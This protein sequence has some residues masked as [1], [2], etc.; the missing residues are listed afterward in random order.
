MDEES[1]NDSYSVDPTPRRSVEPV[2][3]AAG[4]DR[5]EDEEDA[6]SYFARLAE[7]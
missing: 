1:D 2:A 6:L 3:V 5:D 7:D 4:V